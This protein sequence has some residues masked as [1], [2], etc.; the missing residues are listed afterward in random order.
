MNSVVGF[1][2]IM[3]NQDYGF[4]PIILVGSGSS[5][6]LHPNLKVEYGINNRI[7]IQVRSGS[8]SSLMVGS[9]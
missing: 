2:F 7:R 1:I 3:N 6:D 8:G 9:G 5:F 4:D